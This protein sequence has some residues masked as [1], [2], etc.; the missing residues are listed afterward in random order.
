MLC[1]LCNKN[2]AVCERY[3]ESTVGNIKVPLCL[4]CMHK[5]LEQAEEPKQI[6][7][8]WDSESYEIC[9][10]CCKTSLDDFLASNYLGCSK[11]YEVFRA[12][13]ER[14]VATIHGRNVHVGKV[15]EK[16][17]DGNTKKYNDLQKAKVFGDYKKVNNLNENLFKGGF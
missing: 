15:P 16:V 2:E 17:F 7:D 13:I 5:V 10:P 3:I 6:S 12:D 4:D 11:C 9:C 1:S 8:F 14:V